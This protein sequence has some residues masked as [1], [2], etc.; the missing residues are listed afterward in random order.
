MIQQPSIGNTETGP[1]NPDG[2]FHV[3]RTDGQAST[4][5]T[6]NGNTAT[7]TS[8]YSTNNCTETYQVTFTL[9]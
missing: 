8:S 9:Q 5:G 3:Q 2:S 7:A 4:N 1:I 6:I